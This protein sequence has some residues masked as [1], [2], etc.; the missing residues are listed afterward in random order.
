MQRFS[1]RFAIALTLILGISAATVW[2]LKHPASSRT[3]EEENIV[4]VVFRYQMDEENKAEGATIFFLSR[5]KDTDPSDGFMRRFEGIR[6][7]R[8]F[9]QS[10]KVS[11]GVRDQATGERG[12]ILD[13]HRIEWLNEAEVKVGVGTFVWGGGQSGSVCRVVRENGKWAVKECELT[14]IT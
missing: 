10:K 13:V 2:Y 9:S 6:G 3:A 8:R 11:D 4:E 1:P 5:P 7:V 14:L 12:I